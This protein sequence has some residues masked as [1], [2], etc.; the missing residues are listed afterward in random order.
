MTLTPYQKNVHV[1]CAFLEEHGFE[2]ALVGG[3][4]AG[5]WGVTRTTFDVDAVVAADASTLEQLRAAIGPPSFLFEPEC[6]QFPDMMILRAHVLEPDN[7]VEPGVT[8]VD[9]LA[10][11]L[12]LS[13]SI[14]RRRGKEPL[15]GRDC[16]VCSPEDLILLKLIAGR[17]KDLEDIKG[18]LA[19]RQEKLDQSYLQE[20]IARLGKQ[21]AWA[22]VLAHPITLKY[23]P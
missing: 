12:S 10:M 22:E 6:L 23:K 7:P 3:L 11:E 21:A 16:W 8:V 15:W 19:E 9:L 4:A 1:V 5:I 2:Y 20:W 13:Q 14:L 17:V 18:I